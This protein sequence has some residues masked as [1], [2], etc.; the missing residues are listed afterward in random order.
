MVRIAL[1]VSTFPVLSE[2]FIVRQWLGLLDRGWDAHI[3]C[4]RLDLEVWQQM[5]DL[6]SR[7]ELLARTHCI[8]PTTSKLRAALHLPKVLFSCMKHPRSTGR[9]WRLSI[10]RGW[11]HALRRLY[12]DAPLLEINPQ[13][14]HF[15]FGS[16]APARMDLGKILNAH[17]VVS[18]RG[19]DLAFVGLG[20]DSYYDPVWQLADGLHLL[21]NDLRRR[22][23]D[24]GCDPGTHHALI[25]PAVDSSRFKPE[26]RPDRPEGPL[27]IISVGRLVWKKGYH[28]A[29]RAVRLLVDAG[30]PCCYTLVGTGPEIEA[31]AYA[32]HQLGL[33]EVVHLRGSLPRPQ[34]LEALAN[35]DVFLH[36]AVSEG[37]CNAVLEAQA[38]ALPVVTTDADGLSENVCDGETGFVEPRRNPEALARRLAQLAKDSDLRHRMGQAGRRRV[39]VSFHP[40][41]EIDRFENLYRSTLAKPRRAEALAAEALAAEAL[42]NEQT[43]TRS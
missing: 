22:A 39:Q 29:I 5:E 37:F 2:T 23:L 8:G 24:R 4:S 19:F 27:R 35:A 6:S 13:L 11:S 14:I 34:V 9:H 15:E 10:P 28:Y 33:D 18:F 3:A 21:G 42:T 32:C 17:L 7:P 1:I 25:A 31:V 20:D 26:A 40:E 12:L 36:P 41:L 16:L 38:M 43:G 30:I